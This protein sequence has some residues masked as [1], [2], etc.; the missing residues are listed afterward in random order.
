MEQ[1][2]QTKPDKKK[3]PL[4]NAINWTD[5]DLDDLSSINKADLK[6]AGALWQH[7]APQPLQGLLSAKVKAQKESSEQA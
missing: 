2:K 7:E 5:S 4:G 6:A 1:T 3:K